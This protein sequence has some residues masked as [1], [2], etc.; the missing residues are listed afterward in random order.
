M[1]DPFNALQYAEDMA[2]PLS[3]LSYA[4]QSAKRNLPVDV[5]LARA[6]M[7]SVTAVYGPDYRVEVMSGAQGKGSRGMTGSRRHT[8]GKA[9]DVWIYAP[10]GHKL[11]G[12]ELVPV[13]QHWL[14]T[15]QGSVGFPAKSGQSLH[16]D[17]IGGA[18]KGAVPRKAGE[19]SI[20]YYGTP[21]K[22][23]REAL[24]SGTLP[25]Y[26][27]PPAT[28]AKGM[29][30]PADIPKVATAT[31]TAPV[32][33]PVAMSPGLRGI[34]ANYDKP[35]T[36][37]DISR[38]VF[39]KP[40]TDV[41][42]L[43]EGILPATRTPA[44]VTMSPALTAARQRLQAAREGK[45]IPVV[46]KVLTA[47]ATP[48]GSVKGIETVPLVP[49]TANRNIR[50]QQR[51][52]LRLKEPA[53]TALAGTVALPAGVRP[54][55]LPPPPK[56]DPLLTGNALGS[57]ARGNALTFQDRVNMAV[58]GAKAKAVQQVAAD[59]TRKQAKVQAQQ[60]ALVAPTAGPSLFDLAKMAQNQ[61]DTAH[62]L[63]RR[64]TDNSLVGGQDD[65]YYRPLQRNTDGP[66]G[67]ELR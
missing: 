23:Q 34:K 37:L 17:F 33:K 42:S 41:A 32:P 45:A 39:G 24:S 16:L 22:A 64:P 36:A 65:M 19:G 62:L 15:K 11:A 56:V 28:V 59:T 49:Q 9:A 46:S 20:W 51:E 43:Y 27:I 6:I 18:G 12:D 63:S 25:K 5:A 7:E 35:D 29:I 44:P 21:S 31:S 1:A 40:K 57:N 26:V 4:N 8:T 61:N 67:T 55:S 66:G 2:V 53:R 10:D 47:S 58:A 30:P 3:A 14:G 13:S 54:A 50:T 38:Q 48:T 60:A 52:Q